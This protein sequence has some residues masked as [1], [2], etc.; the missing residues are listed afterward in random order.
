MRNFTIIPNELLGESQLSIPSRY[1]YCVLLKYTGQN[2]WCFPSQK[3]LAKNLNCSDRHIRNLIEEL[4]ENELIYKVRR[5]FNRSN[6]YKVAKSLT[7]Y[8][9]S[10]GNSNSSH[11]GSM[12]PLHTGN[13]VPAK[14][15]YLKAK[16]KRSVKGLEKLRESMEEKGIIRR[17]EKRIGQK[18]SLLRCSGLSRSLCVAKT[19]EDGSKKNEEY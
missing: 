4:E 18:V 1:L 14:S 17:S 10:N 11:L 9:Q 8:R 13:E 6:N 19:L 15:T 12:L 5:G 2:E 7:Y 3:T 16:A